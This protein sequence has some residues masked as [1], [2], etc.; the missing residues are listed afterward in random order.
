MPKPTKETKRIMYIGYPGDQG[1]SFMFHGSIEFPAR[2]VVPVSDELYECVR[3]IHKFTTVDAVTYTLLD[4]PN[5][6]VSGVNF[7]ATEDNLV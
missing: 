6:I 7:F 5:R 3:H 4:F 2:T 1:T